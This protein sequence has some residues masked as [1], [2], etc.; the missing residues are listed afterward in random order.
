VDSR[1]SYRV[2]FKR[3][4]GISSSEKLSLDFPSLLVEDEWRE[5]VVGETVEVWSGSASWGCEAGA[6]TV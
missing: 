1:D 4:S 5:L 6:E 3:A 2:F